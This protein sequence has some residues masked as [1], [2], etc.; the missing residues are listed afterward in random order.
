[1]QLPVENKS[2]GEFLRWV[3]KDVLKEE[4]DTIIKSQFDV[5][6]LNSAVSN[7]ARM[8]FLNQI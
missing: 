8:W 1:M 6:K 2:T 3:V 4:E 7:A 5:K